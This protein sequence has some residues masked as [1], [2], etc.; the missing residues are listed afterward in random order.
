[1]KRGRKNA[2]EQ[3]ALARFPLK[4]LAPSSHLNAEQQEIWNEVVSTRPAESFSEEHKA[5][6]E[7]YCLHSVL[8]RRLN[9]GLDSFSAKKMATS[10]GKA[11][12]AEQKSQSEAVRKLATSLC[13]APKTTQRVSHRNKRLTALHE[14]VSALP[15]DDSSEAKP[16]AGSALEVWDTDKTTEKA[17]GR[18]WSMGRSFPTRSGRNA[19][20]IEECCVVPQGALVGQAVKLTTKQKKWLR[21]IYDTPTRTF[22]LSMGRKN[23]KTAFVAFLLLLHL[24]GPESKANS[25]LFSAAQSR[26]QASILFKYA[27]KCVRLSL[28]LYP[29]IH[30]RDTTKQLACPGQG[31]LYRALSA[32][33]ATS[34]GLS[35]AFLV[36]DELGQV[37]GPHSELYEALETAGAA[38][39]S[40]LSIIISTQART[41]NDLLSILIDDAL[42]GA[43]PTIKIDLY[44]VPLEGADG[45]P[46]DNALDI[47]SVKAIRLANPH[48]DELMNKEEVLRKAA[49]AKR[50]PTRE[51]SYRN[52]VL[53]QRV[54]AKSPF[55]SR[56]VWLENGAE[57]PDLRGQTVY[58]G[59][60]L[61]SVN[62][63]C[64][65]VLVGREQGSIVPTFWLPE[66]GLREKSIADRTPYD[67]W[68]K[69][70]FLR[71]TP[72]RSVEYEHIAAFLRGVFDAFSIA[73]IAFDRYNMKFLRPW[74]IKEGFTADEVEEKFIPFG[75]GFVSMSPA[76]REMESGLL[77]GKFKHGRHPVL[78]MCVANAAVQEDSAGNRKFVKRQAI[79]RIDGAVALAEAI[80]AMSLK[81]EA[82]PE[83][84]YQVLFM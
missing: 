18:W 51:A 19:W 70:G 22:I 15:A 79:R 5:L 82:A 50:I 33:V 56:S 57:P 43:D 2:N 63:L 12:L 78:N 8:L 69:Q 21:Q 16:A 26:D 37:R 4:R 54:E 73:A 1:M 30:I 25:E 28:N 77:A 10:E 83:K 76:L 72:G 80:G 64:A 55:V 48:F 75:Q 35:T 53:N 27:A 9:E 34:Y 68:K 20:W 13:L 42:T 84:K 23:A 38:E 3:A 81:A 65:L 7:A 17:R 71:T 40:P 67:V 66:E 11:L 52:L 29:I 36:H 47:F 74:L 59:L 41:D 44:T 6:L 58:G 62:D 45:A 60:D 31:T 24:C 61:S 46:G 32:E 49:D 39:E 14:R